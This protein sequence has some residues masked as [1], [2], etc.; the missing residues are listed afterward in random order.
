MKKALIKN[1]NDDVYCRIKASKRHGVGVFAIKDI[2]KDTNPFLLTGAQCIKQK[3]INVSE[4][5]LKTL[6]PEVK[7]M[8]NDSYNIRNI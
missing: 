1:L 3:I 7:K 5:E 2:P 4:D 6:H 8:V